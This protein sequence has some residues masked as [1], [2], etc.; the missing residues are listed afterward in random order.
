[1]YETIHKT[2]ACPSDT[3][4]CGTVWN[5][6]S[7]PFNRSR[8]S[9]RYLRST[10]VLE[11]PHCVRLQPKLLLHRPLVLQR[12]V[13]SRLLLWSGFILQPKFL[14]YR[15]LVLQLAVQSIQV[16]HRPHLL[17]SAVQSAICGAIQHTSQQPA[18]LLRRLQYSIR[19]SSAEFFVWRFRG[20]KGVHTR[21]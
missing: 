14:L 6:R 20:R 3:R 12:A 19:L 18:A 10:G 11:T 17:Q 4:T 7:P 13:Q 15:S 2:H 1:M 21:Q 16:L 5:S 9:Q 8:P